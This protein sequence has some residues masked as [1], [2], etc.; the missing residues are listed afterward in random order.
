[1]RGQSRCDGERHGQRQRHQADGD[2]CEH[3]M[4]KIVGSTTRTPKAIFAACVRGRKVCSR[5]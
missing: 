2:S 3:V 5:S 4:Q 1:L